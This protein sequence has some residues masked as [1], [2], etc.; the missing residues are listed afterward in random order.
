MPYVKEEIF[1]LLKGKND[2]TSSPSDFDC[3]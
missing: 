3:L 2:I 1:R